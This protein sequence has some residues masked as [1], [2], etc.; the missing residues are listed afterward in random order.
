[1][2]ISKNLWENLFFFYP[3]VESWKAMLM[4]LNVC[5]PFASFVLCDQ[6][7]FP[8]KICV[9]IGL[10]ITNLVRANSSISFT[11]ADACRT[12]KCRQPNRKTYEDMNWFAEKSSCLPRAILLHQSIFNSL[13]SLNMDGISNQI[14]TSTVHWFL[15]LLCW[16]VIQVLISKVRFSKKK[17]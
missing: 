4:T 16:T 6:T 11:Y 3:R 15:S 17:Y 8:I 2:Q 7:L 12:D 5:A 13:A 10:V 14:I 1:M 9:S